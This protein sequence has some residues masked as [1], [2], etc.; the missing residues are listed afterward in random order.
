MKSR[1][2]RDTSCRVFGV[3]LQNTDGGEDKSKLICP[4]CKR[5]GH[6]KEAC[7]ELIGYP[8]WWGERGGKSQRGRGRGGIRANAAVVTGFEGQ[9]A[10]AVK[11]GFTG[12]NNEQWKTLIQILDSQ[13]KGASTS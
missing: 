5:K 6:S 12:L 7:F 10:D 11:N 2:S 4:N 8:T 3:C 9:S 13:S 1:G